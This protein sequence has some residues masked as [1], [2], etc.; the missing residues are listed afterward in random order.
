MPYRNTVWATLEQWTPIAFLAAGGLFALP[1]VASGVDAL[2]GTEIALS[3]AVIF[4]FML[5]LF[6]GLLGLYPRLAERGSTL[7]KGGVGLLAVTAAITIPAVG[8]FMPSTG[9]AIGEV[10]A[11]AIV[12]TVAVGSTLAVTTFGVASLRTRAHSRPFGGFLLVMAA[13]MSLMIVAKVMYGHST[14]AWVGFVVNGLVAMSSGSIGYMLRTEDIQT[15]S[16]DSTGDVTA[17]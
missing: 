1:A 16:T 7:A 9:L 17:S 12:M 14:P 4:I 6:V 8:V 15:E 13:G 3:P 10:T 2:T 11:L 5:A